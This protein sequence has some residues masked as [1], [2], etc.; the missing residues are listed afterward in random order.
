MSN[1]LK[2][3]GASM[4][5]EARLSYVTLEKPKVIT[6][7]SPP[8]YG[9]VLMIPKSDTK[10]MDAVRA[11]IE[12]AKENDTGNLK[13][14]KKIKQVLKD[15][16]HEDYLEE[17]NYHGHYIINAYSNENKPPQLRVL[18]DGAIAEAKPGDIYSGCWA[19]VTINFYTYNISGA[20]IAAGLNN[21]LKLRDDERFAGGRSAEE[22]FSDL[23]SDDDMI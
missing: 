8:K 18:K 4:R 7:D 13:G 9:V 22:D 11:A 23:T 20:G 6:K 1:V 16:D 12:A 10:T 3:N 21:V 19:A 14:A 5:L 17:T 2:Q 15:G